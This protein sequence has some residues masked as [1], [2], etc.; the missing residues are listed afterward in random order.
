MTD[1]TFIPEVRKPR[2]G[3][4]QL[5]CTKAY[6]DGSSYATLER[7]TPE[8]LRSVYECLD[9]HFTEQRRDYDY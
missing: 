3:E 6:D 5:V 7:F 1:Y 8:E 4:L 9:A 2:S